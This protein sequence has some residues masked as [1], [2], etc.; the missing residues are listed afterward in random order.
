MVVETCADVSVGCG[1]ASMG[2]IASFVGSAFGE[3]RWLRFPSG[4][5]HRASASPRELHCCCAKRWGGTLQVSG[6]QHL[7]FYFF[8]TYLPWCGQASV[9]SCLAAAS[10]HQDVVRGSKREAQ[11][12]NSKIN[13]INIK[14]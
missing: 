5:I 8:F 2:K 10:S 14:K 11:N 4:S 9:Q 1:L 7:H 13:K 12:C 6:V 3:Q